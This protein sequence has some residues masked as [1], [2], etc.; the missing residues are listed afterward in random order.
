MQREEEIRIAGSL[1]DHLERGTTDVVDELLSNPVSSYTS[2]EQL[3]R[4]WRE[5]FGAWPLLV[6]FSCQIPEPGDWLTDDFA[7]VPILVVRGAD[8]RAH[9]FANV[10]RHRGSRVVEGCGRGARGFVCPY[11]AWRYD[12]DGKLAAIPDAYGFEGLDRDAHGLRRLPI[13]EA[14]GLLWVVADVGAVERPVDLASHLGPL[15]DELS[16]YR[17]A[18][19]HF[20]TTRILRRRMNWKLVIDTFGEAYHLKPLHR[21]TVASIYHQN[22]EVCRGHGPHHS[23]TLARRTIES[24]RDVPRSEW[25]LI[26]HAVVV[27]VF[28]PNVVFSVQGDHV[29][30]VRV[31]PVPGR[32]DECIVA[33]DWL[34]PEA[35]TSEKAKQH[36]DKNV[37]LFLRTVDD[38]DFATAEGIQRGFA[39]GVQ[40]HLTYGR[41]EVPLQRYHRTLRRVLD[42]P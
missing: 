39:S 1:L 23:M 11:H 10:C 41:Y 16:A 13:A 6:G 14:D 24:L 5:L 28:F 18:D 7:P 4:E 9:A 36:W 32:V 3:G 33:V 25:R 37:D 21:A 20:Y 22:V 8:G 40:T 27:Y 31:Y 34:V 38:E 42:L 30:V 12:L 29:D 15:A 2:E 19:Y 17:F 26:P 35:P